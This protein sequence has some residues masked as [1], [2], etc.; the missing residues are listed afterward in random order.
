[1]NSGVAAPVETPRDEPI[2]VG[3][4]APEFTLKTANAAG[5]RGVG[6]SVSLG[7]LVAR[8]PVIVEFLRG[9]W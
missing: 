6:E 1:M 4:R 5:G 8:G 7:E 3:E 2:T 9:T